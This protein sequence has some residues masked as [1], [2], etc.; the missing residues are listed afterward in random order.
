MKFPG[1]GENK[2]K[3]GRSRTVSGRGNAEK[4][5]V[6]FGRLLEPSPAELRLRAVLDASAPTI[7]D[8]MSLKLDMGKHGGVSPGRDAA[9][10]ATGEGPPTLSVHEIARLSGRHGLTDVT[11]NPS[12][13]GARR[14]CPPAVATAWNAAWLCWRFSEE[15]EVTALLG[16]AAAGQVASLAQRHGVGEW[17]TMDEA[18]SRLAQRAGVDPA[19][20]RHQARRAWRRLGE[21][22]PGAVE[23]WQHAS[24]DV[25]QVLRRAAELE[26]VA[27]RIASAQGAVQAEEGEIGAAHAAARGA[28]DALLRAVDDATPLLPLGSMPHRGPPEDP[29]GGA[30]QHPHRFD[31]SGAVASGREEG[32]ARAIDAVAEGRETEHY[33][34]GPT[35][36]IPK[37]RSPARGR[38]ATGSADSESVTGDG[39][40]PP[41]ASEAQPKRQHAP[42]SDAGSAPTLDEPRRP[43]PQPSADGGLNREAVQ[44][45]FSD[46]RGPASRSAAAGEERHDP[47]AAR[48]RRVAGYRD[49]EATTRDRL[50]GPMRRVQALVARALAADQS[51]FRPTTPPLSPARGRVRSRRRRR[52]HGATAAEDGP[53]EGSGEGDPPRARRPRSAPGTAARAPGSVGTGAVQSSARGQGKTTEPAAAPNASPAS[54]GLVVRGR[55]PQR[56][57]CEMP[58]PLARARGARPATGAGRVAVQTPARGRRKSS[59]PAAP[60]ADPAPSGLVVR[61]RSPQRSGCELPAS[62]ANAGGAARRGG[63]PVVDPVSLELPREASTPTALTSPPPSPLHAAGTPAP[64]ANTAERHTVPAVPASKRD[65]RS[66]D[67]PAQEQEVPA[68]QSEVGSSARPRPRSASPRGPKRVVQA[69]EEPLA[70][71]RRALRRTLDLTDAD[72]GTD[73]ATRTVPSLRVLRALQGDG[74]LALSP[75]EARLLLPVAGGDGSDVGTPP[76]STKRRVRA[77][78]LVDALLPLV[79]PTPD[80][81]AFRAVDIAFEALA[82]RCGHSGEDS[83]P[84]CDVAK[85]YASAVADA[86]SSRSHRLEGWISSLHP[87]LP[88]MALSRDDLAC[89]ARGSEAGSDGPIPPSAQLLL[90]STIP[91]TRA[92][93]RDYFSAVGDGAVWEACSRSPPL[94]APQVAQR[95]TDAVVAEV[96]GAWRSVLA[97]ATVSSADLR[98]LKRRPTRPS[99][100]EPRVQLQPEPSPPASR[101]AAGAAIARPSSHGIASRRV[102]ASGEEDEAEESG[103]ALARAA[104]HQRLIYAETCRIRDMEAALG[105]RR[106]LLARARAVG[107]Q[108][109]REL[110]RALAGLVQQ[111]TCVA[112]LGGGGALLGRGYPHDLDAV[113]SLRAVLLQ[114]ACLVAVPPS[115]ARMRPLQVLDLSHNSLRSLD[116]AI[117]ALPNLRLLDASHNRLRSAPAELWRMPRLCTLDLSCNALSQLP[118]PLAAGE[119][120][121]P[122][123]ALLELRVGGNRLQDLAAVG[124]LA[125]AAGLPCLHTLDASDN[126]IADLGS[127]ALAQLPALRS[128][129]L[130]TNHLTWLDPT[131]FLPPCL[132]TLCLGGNALDRL[133]EWGEVEEQASAGELPGGLPTLTRLDLSDNPLR[134]FPAWLLQQCPHL[135]RLAL[136]G[137]RL[138]RMPPMPPQGGCSGALRELFLHDCRLRAVPPGLELCT[139]MRVL[140]AHGNRLRSVPPALAALHGLQAVSLH[141]NRLPALPASVSGWSS[142]AL[143]RIGSQRPRKRDTDRAGLAA[144]PRSPR[145]RAGPL[146]PAAS[147]LLSHPVL[148]RIGCFRDVDATTAAWA[149]AKAAHAMDRK[150]SGGSSKAQD[151]GGSGAYEPPPVVELGAPGHSQPL[152][153]LFGDGGAGQTGDRTR[154]KGR[155]E[156]TPGDSSVAPPQGQLWGRGMDPVAVEGV[157]PAT[158][159]DLGPSEGSD[160]R[161]QGGEAPTQEESHG[162]EAARR[163]LADQAAEL[164][165]LGAGSWA[166]SFPSWSPGSP[167]LCAR[168]CA[169]PAQ[170]PAR[171]PRCNDSGCRDRA[172]GGAVA[173][174]GR[175]RFPPGRGRLATPRPHLPGDSCPVLVPARRTGCPRAQRCAARRGR[176]ASRAYFQD[177]QQA[178]SE[179]RQRR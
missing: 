126:R 39:D 136:G 90:N 20:Q 14:R 110:R 9:G 142:L 65:D 10:A 6:D 132:E 17:E 5:G 33:A 45:P 64:D 147:A 96:T 166:N 152:R 48:M 133:P 151:G 22:D 97:G 175:R 167:L 124:Q 113:G 161:E 60:Q 138:S 42:A 129:D 71:W 162:V 145:H 177:W 51:R 156:P 165:A 140:T 61:G 11:G 1:P 116:P 94:D 100:P 74:A 86:P 171:S 66:P 68:T 159:A 47:I 120:Q 112:P 157:G 117:A 46:A 125:A 77:E 91:V 69:V 59:E 143:L 88:D 89:L 19:T 118:A 21:L 172:R 127:A 139:S 101:K 55:S 131:A 168:P 52:E 148:R 63:A 178:R 107:A 25:L 176:R 154:A 130:S 82:A 78:A 56:S 122:A 85:A 15:E 128:L 31:G 53:L 28:K 121:C 26:E 93:F 104:R 137:T 105:R 75:E 134:R 2:D 179:C 108:C 50:V 18:R 102:D 84:L 87:R 3:H 8:N 13:L 32:L 7:E 92:L 30:A 70:A 115:V 98:V 36:W 170:A 103:G 62:L 72:A 149:A 111:H 164:D 135:D 160:Q 123:P 114:S 23:R 163:A 29:T 12:S 169:S 95:A 58:V 119:E 73:S 16:R 76:A 24:L 38:E 144:L 40:G 146:S 27:A 174:V 49:L 173:A 79:L 4:R 99:P 83:I 57:G 158:V 155:V 43:A 153:Q 106:S 67:S 109:E 150:E 141:A 80:G 44:P 34:T 54:S 35:R 37:F 81:S 41:P